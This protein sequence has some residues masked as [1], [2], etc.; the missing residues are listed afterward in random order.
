M[1]KSIETI[2][3]PTPLECDPAAHFVIDNGSTQTT[4]GLS[5]V[6]Q[7]LRI[8]EMQGD[9]PQLPKEWWYPLIT[10]HHIKMEM[11]ENIQAECQ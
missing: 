2:D 4:L 1:I 8:A 5:V 9:V 10:R 6:L 3:I 7:C 11:N